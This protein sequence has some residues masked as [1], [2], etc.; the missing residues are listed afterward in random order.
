NEQAPWDQQAPWDERALAAQPYGDGVDDGDRPYDDLLPDDDDTGALAPLPARTHPVRALQTAVTATAA[1]AALAAGT[2]VAPVVGVVIAVL[3][4]VVLRTVGR[5][6]ERLRDR[7]DRRG[8][9]RRDP[10][11][12]TLGAPWHLLLA[13][14]DTLTALPLMLLVAA[15]PAGAV[16]LLDPVVTGL[17]RDE[18]TVATATVVA[19]VVGLSRRVHRRSRLLLRRT[20]L[21]L[22]PGAASGV[23]LV[24]ALT[25][26]AVL[27][28]ATA[29]GRAP[30]WWPLDG[31]V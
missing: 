13:L 9:R 1:L 6:G 4:L 10:V 29:E 11:V 5:C 23:A 7:R 26:I 24:L 21:T 20:V 22:T 2:L 30:T 8:D 25:L 16:Y 12:A 17:E 14:G 18:L 15:V 28:L 3:L 19:L 27:L 31:L